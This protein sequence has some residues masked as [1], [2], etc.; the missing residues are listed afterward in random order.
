[1]KG[2]IWTIKQ[3][4]KWKAE[5]RFYRE[6]VDKVAEQL[7]L[8]DEIIIYNGLVVA[9]VPYLCMYLKRY[10]HPCRYGDLL[11]HFP[12]PVPELS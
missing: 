10:A 8:P 6:D 7:Q 5:F 11:Y 9:S 1:M 4:T 2:L 3:T 12:R